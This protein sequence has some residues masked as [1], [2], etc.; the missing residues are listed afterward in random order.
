[1]QMCFFAL[2]FISML[3]NFGRHTE[4]LTNIVLIRDAF[5]SMTIIRK[6]R[7]SCVTSLETETYG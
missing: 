5:I 7:E 4:V 2:Q 3:K 1:M 6:F